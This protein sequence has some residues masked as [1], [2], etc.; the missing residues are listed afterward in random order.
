MLNE[1]GVVDDYEF[2]DNTN[3]TEAS[4]G[5]LMGA[6]GAS[7]AALQGCPDIFE[8]ES[9]DFAVIGSDITELSA[10]HL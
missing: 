6:N 5:G 2:S 1:G 4:T 9:G 3:S 10:S 8:L 7:T